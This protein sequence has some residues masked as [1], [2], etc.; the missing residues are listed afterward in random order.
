M[1]QPVERF[2]K[3]AANRDLIRVNIRN[4]QC[5]QVFQIGRD[6]VDIANQEKQLQHVYVLRLQ[7]VARLRRAIGAIH[8]AANRAVQKG[9]HGVV[10]IIE[11]NKRI[12]T[13]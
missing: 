6:A 1:H 11:G 2:L 7:T 8:D 9:M 12:C 3:R 10:K 4:H 5:R 13:E